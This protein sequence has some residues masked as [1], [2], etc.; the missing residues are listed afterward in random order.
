MAMGP[1]AESEAEVLTTRSGTA[2]PPRL[3]VTLVTPTASLRAG[4]VDE[5]IAPGVEGELGVLPGHVPYITALKPGVLVLRDGTRR[6]VY[7]VGQGYLQ[8]GV[9][10]QTRVLAQ[11]AVPGADVDGDQAR[12]DKA[13]AE[14]ELK[15][16]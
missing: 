2:P 4:D 8:V 10:G 14:E 5:I 7:A 16:A 13:A 9:G 6:D 12:S 15:A 11:M 1:H 3:G